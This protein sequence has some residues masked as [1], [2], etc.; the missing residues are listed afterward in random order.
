MLNGVMLNAVQ[1]AVV[2]PYFA[3]TPKKQ[4]LEKIYY[5]PT[6]ILRPNEQPLTF[7]AACSP[8]SPI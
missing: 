1:L 2:A 8:Y 5:L 7:S 3:H 6:A 4:K